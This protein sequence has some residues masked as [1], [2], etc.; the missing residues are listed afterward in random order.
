MAEA[1]DRKL[2][3][4]LREGIDVVRMIFFKNLKDYLQ[5]KFPEDGMPMPVCL[6]VQ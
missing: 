6:P 3:P 4:S 2:I 5:K 1:F